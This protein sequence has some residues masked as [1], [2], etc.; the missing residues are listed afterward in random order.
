M[1][2]TAIN[3][4]LSPK[5]AA[6]GYINQYGGLVRTARRQNF[7][8]TEDGQVIETVADVFP[9]SCSTT[10]TECWQE[11]KYMALAPNSALASVAWIERLSPVGVEA[12]TRDGSLSASLRLV[13]WL[14]L[15]MMGQTGCGVPLEIESDLMNLLTASGNV[16]AG[17]SATFT[18][19]AIHL[20]DDWETIFGKYSF[21]RNVGYYMYPYSFLAIDFTAKITYAKNCLIPFTPATRI[22]CY[23]I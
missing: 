17:I 15:P 21:D 6:L 22:E 2:Q 23:T 4:I 14:N 20:D 13:V 12:D 16:Q 11:G 9:V 19:K 5:I 1:I 8:Q 3:A 18:P 7:I 10:F